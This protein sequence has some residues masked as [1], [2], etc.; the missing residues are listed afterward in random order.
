MTYPTESDLLIS[1]HRTKKISYNELDFN[2]FKE[3]L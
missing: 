1:N 2:N 3:L